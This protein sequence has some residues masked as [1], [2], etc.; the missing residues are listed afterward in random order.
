MSVV[1]MVKKDPEPV[2]VPRWN[3][4]LNHIMHRVA[5]AR[6]G[7][8]VYSDAF[9]VLVDILKE[10]ISNE[11]QNVIAIIGSTGSGK[12]TVAVQLCLKMDPFFSFAKDYIYSIDDL[13]DKLD[14]KHGQSSPVS[15]FDEGSI[16]LNSL[17]FS[18]KGDKDIVV[19]FDTM[20]SRGWTTVICTP[21][22]R[23]LNNRVRED[24]VNFLITC[25]G[26]SPVKG[27]SSRGFFKIHKKAKNSSFQNKP[28]WRPICYGIAQK[29]PPKVDREYQKYK[30]ASQDRLINEII[31]K[32]RNEK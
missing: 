20:R 9:D 11:R 27:Y 22:L 5:V 25:G 12:S 31:E 2:G 3:P 32:Q 7:L 14:G 8:P 23:N 13:V 15:L 29:M 1:S 26:R 24:H 18:R 19:L 17:N 28:Y 21:E 10:R 4:E 6:D 30:K 16:I